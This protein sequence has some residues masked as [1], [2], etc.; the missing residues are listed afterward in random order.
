MK[1]YSGVAELFSIYLFLQDVDQ[2]SIIHVAFVVKICF[3][4]HSHKQLYVLKT[5]STLMVEM[6][7][8]TI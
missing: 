2:V 1:G 7:M 6:W 8:F 5:Y 4:V 3:I